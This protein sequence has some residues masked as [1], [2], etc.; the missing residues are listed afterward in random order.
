MPDGLRL[1]RTAAVALLF[2]GGVTGCGGAG[3]QGD[4]GG[5]ETGSAPADAGPDSPY[6]FVWTTDSDSVD[7]NFLAVVDAG[8]ASDTYGEVL[9]TLPVPTEGSIRGHHTEHRMPEGGVLLAND[10]RTGKTY[11]LDLRNPLE[12]AVADSFT[13]AGPLTFPHSFERLSTGAIIATFQTEGQGNSRA[14]GIAALT[15]GGRLLMY[16]SAAAGGNDVRPYS[17]AV[18]PALDRVVTG[19]ADM[20]GQVDRRVVQVWRGSDLQLLH[21]IDFPDEWGRAAEPRVLA[22]G[23]TV[24]VS[25]FGC[26]LL[27]VVGLDGD[28]PS[29]ERVWEFG[30][31]SCALPV[32]VG[33]FWIQA[34]PSVNGLVALDVS[35]PANPVEAARV[36][37]DEDD[38]PHWISLSPNERRIVVTGYAGTRH[39]VIL[40]DLDPQTGQ[41]SVDTDFGTPGADRPGITFDRNV[42]PHGETG[43]GDPHGVVFSR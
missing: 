40:V 29:L 21:T 32:V 38:W 30:G 15:P 43:P 8:R 7:L 35:D 14:G 1:I 23:E 36:S 42:W 2:A 18:A 27:R 34:V 26:S 25:T 11:L 5:G 41:M 24:L 16:G 33:N 22:D 10:F 39:R 20:R 37:L 6:L 17:L 9:T 3:D 13:A 4:A 19:S 31:S 28:E 12:P